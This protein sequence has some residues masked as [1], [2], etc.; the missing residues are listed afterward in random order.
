MTMTPKMTY[1]LWPLGTDADAMWELGDS[2]E[3]THAPHLAHPG[4]I[5]SLGCPHHHLVHA[6][7]GSSRNGSGL[8]RTKHNDRRLLELTPAIVELSPCSAMGLLQVTGVAGA[9]SRAHHAPLSH[10]RYFFTS[11]T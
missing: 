3:G 5:K 6:T 4:V 9:A 11:P 2:K 10:L 1:A 7:S 8:W